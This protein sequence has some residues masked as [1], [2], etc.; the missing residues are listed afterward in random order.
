MYGTDYVRTWRCHSH[1]SS[2]SYLF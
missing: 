1:Q 2:L